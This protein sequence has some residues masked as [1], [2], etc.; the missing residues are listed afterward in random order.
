MASFQSYLSPFST[1]STKE[2]LDN[3]LS[4]LAQMET[5]LYDSIGRGTTSSRAPQLIEE[6]INAAHLNQY[7][8]GFEFDP[9]TADNTNN[10]APGVDGTNG[11]NSYTEGD[12]RRTFNTQIFAKKAEV[13]GTESATDAVRYQGKKRMAEQLAIMGM[14]LKRDVEFACVGA[15]NRAGAGGNATTARQIVGAFNQIATGTTVSPANADDDWSTATVANVEA[16]INELAEAV[17][18]AGGIT[19]K[20]G[21]AFVKNAN[22]MLMSPRN[23]RHLDRLLDGKANSRRD[24]SNFEIQGQHF[25]KYASSFGDFAVVPDLQCTHSDV[26]MYNPQNWAWVNLRATHIQDIAKVGDA[27]RKMIVMEGCLIHRHTSA[28]GKLSGLETAA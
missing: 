18:A 7:V 22:M 23:K 27:E 2:N 11:D 19:Y 13:S 26:L 5:P 1:G 9:A 6:T 8:E 14:E 25:S 3:K 17:Y 24:I 10:P 20:M 12:A 16:D 15:A 28:S 21:N 4:L